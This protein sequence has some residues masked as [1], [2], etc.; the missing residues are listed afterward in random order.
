[1]AR[2]IKK[3]A[4]FKKNHRCQWQEGFCTPHFS[5]RID[6]KEA[7]LYAVFRQLTTVCLFRACERHA[8][9]AMRTGEF[10]ISPL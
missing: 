10:N 4:I 7:A 2:T 5:M 1:M 9:R 6:C 3:P 8:L